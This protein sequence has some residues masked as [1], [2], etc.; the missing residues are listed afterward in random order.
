MWGGE[1]H[2]GVSADGALESSSTFGRGAPAAE[3]V[4]QVGR[5]PQVSKLLSQHNAFEGPADSTANPAANAVGFVLTF[6][7]EVA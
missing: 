1:T 7:G 6:V 3:S 4:L 2:A 5:V